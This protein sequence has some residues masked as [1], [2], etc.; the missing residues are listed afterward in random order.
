MERIQILRGLLTAG[1]A[2]LTVL[3]IWAL[4]LAT[5]VL[6]YVIYITGYFIFIILQGFYSD[7]LSACTVCPAGTKGNGPGSGCQ[8]CKEGY[9]SDEGSTTCTICPP[10]TYQ[11]NEK[12]CNLC[13]EGTFA[14]TVGSVQCDVCPLGLFSSRKG[15]TQC[16]TC[17][18]G[19]FSQ[20]GQSCT[21]CNKDIWN[22]S[23]Y[24]TPVAQISIGSIA[25][26][27]LV[28]GIVGTIFWWR[29]R[30]RRGL[31]SIEGGVGEDTSEEE[32]TS[33]DQSDGEEESS[34][35]EE[36]VE[37]EPI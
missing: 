22:V 23:G 11:H 17:D 35:E 19:K 32:T 37:F 10:G 9:I 21:S 4:L 20:D 30:R 15:Q 26:V 28:A 36:V 13:G 8:L 3:P 29:R 34:Y 5:F 7:G 1:I 27:V 14:P 24:C 33:E 12:T 31:Y 6:T 2:L 16:F 18:K 25:F